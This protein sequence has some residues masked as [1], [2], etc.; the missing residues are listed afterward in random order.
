MR[1]FGPDDRDL[2]RSDAATLYEEIVA[3]G[4]IKEGDPRIAA[5]ASERPAFDLLVELGLVSPDREAGVF[6]AVD[7]GTVQSRVV[8]PLGQEGA[9]L[10]DESS[11]WAQA[12]GAL[13]QVWRKSPDTARGPFTVV[14][15]EAIDPFIAGLVAECEEEMLTAQPQT[16]RDRKT[17]AAAA[18]PRHRACSSAGCGC[19]PSTST[20]PGATRSPASTSPRSPNEERRCARSTSSSTG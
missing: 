17:L 2:L 18:R 16:G 14:H 13:A 1:S 11:Q 7:P 5:D 4:G 10:L 20:A 9:R 15:D 3:E 19:A 6:H 12:F 8:A